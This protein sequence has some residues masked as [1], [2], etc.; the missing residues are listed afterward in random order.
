MPPNGVEGFVSLEAGVGW[1]VEI[2]DGEG[3][4]EIGVSSIVSTG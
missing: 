1:E 2:G 4:E 3:K